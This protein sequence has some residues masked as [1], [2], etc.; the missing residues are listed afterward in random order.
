MNLFETILNAQN[1]GVVRQMANNFQL[2]ESQAKSAIGALIPAL[3]Q[4]I[5]QNASNAQGLDSLIG[6]LSRGDHGKYLEDPEML[7]EPAAVEEG[8]KILGHV[9]GSK[10]AS[11]Q[12]ASDA[13]EK[14]GV[15]N[16]ILKKMLPMLASM[17]MGAMANK[18]FGNTSEINQLSAGQ[19]DGLGGLLTGFLDADKDGSTLDDI[20]GMASKFLR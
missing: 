16:S 5:G 19:Q 3:T 8:N 14:S 1:G 17:A 12:V 20:M 10:D 11:R 7:T 18:G 9:L 15:D 2:D 4:G 6:A 13:A